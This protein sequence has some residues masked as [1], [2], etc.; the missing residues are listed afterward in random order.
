MLDVAMKNQLAGI[1]SGLAGN[2]TFDIRVSPQHESKD[3]LLELLNDVASCSDKI[4]CQINDGEGL[5]FT[6]VKDGKPTGIK[7][8][9]VPNGHEFTSLLL[10]ILNS[11][12]KGKNIPDE[13]IQNRVKSLKGPIHLT[14]Y[15]SLTCTNCPDVVQALNAM[16]TLNSGITHETVDGAINQREVEEMKV[17]GVPSVFADGKLIHVG[18]SDFGELLSKLEE[19]YGLNENAGDTKVKDY[20]ILVIGGGPAGSSA[21]IYSARKGLKVGVVAERIGGQVKETVGIENL[22]S[23]PQTTGTKLADDLRT[24]MND[25]AIDMLE[26]RRIEKVEINGIDKLLTTANGEKFSA[27]AV[28]IATGASWRKLN[29]PGETEYIGRGVAFCPHCDGPFYKGKHV[30]VVGGGNSGIEAAIDL[31]GICS[32]VTVLEF[33]DELKADKVLQEKAKSLSNVEIFLHTQSLEV[34]GN[35]E[36]VTGLRIKDRK[37]E[38]ERTIEL[39]GIFIQIGLA[40]NSGPFKEI[41]DTNKPGEIIIDAHCRTNVPGIYA[42]GDVSTVPY[43]QIIIAMGEGAKAALSAFDDRVR[44][45]FG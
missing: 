40:A 22:I 32:K 23:V 4:S 31:A 1:F 10:A 26:H 34:M 9:A 18:R 20:D 5:Q 37:T 19:A 38:A 35:G 45:L 42:A 29:V 6:L 28:I 36:K 15:V 25:Y 14:T 39:D 33:M 30:A 8:R 21:A 13:S 24:H 41:V 12:G 2:Y 44:G 43:K 16:T 27:P 7:F 11:D 3:E 17:Q